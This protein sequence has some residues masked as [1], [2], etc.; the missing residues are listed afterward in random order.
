MF[1]CVA[2]E[3][4]PVLVKLL[5]SVLMTCHE[6]FL[7]VIARLEAFLVTKALSLLFM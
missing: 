4:T 7:L 1:C 3:E 6:M 5:V 2:I